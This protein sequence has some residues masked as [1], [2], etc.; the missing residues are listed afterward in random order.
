MDVATPSIRLVLDTNIYIIGYQFPQSDERRV[1]EVVRQ[2]QDVVIFS[3]AIEDQIRRVGRRVRGKD[4]ASLI[5]NALWQN[6]IIDYVALPDSPFAV[7]EQ[8]APGIP[9]EDVLVFLTAVLGRAECLVS[10]NREFL[11]RSTAAQHTFHCMTP[12]QFLAA[13][14]PQ[15]NR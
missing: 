10:T 3:S 9:T 8:L 11:K 1:L 4:Y 14:L 6:L 2:R 13:Y 12:A 7:A 5:L 15:S